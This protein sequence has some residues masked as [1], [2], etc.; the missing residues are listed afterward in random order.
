MEQPVKILV[1][2]DDN[3][4]RETLVDLLELEGHKVYQA[5]TAAECL[6]ICSSEFFNVILMDYNLPDE[7]GVELIRK[8]RS[9]N[10]DSQ[11]IMITAYAS[12]NAIME[13]MQESVYDF[14]IKPVDFDYLKRTINRA[15]E[16]Y[17]LEESN[18]KLLAQLKT[19]NADL[20]RL[21]NMKSKF[22][23]IVSHDLSNS[24]MT[25]KM[26][27]D[28]LRKNITPDADQQKKMMF[29]DE[30]ISQIEHL[31]RD[32]VDWAA[33][34]KGKLRI[35]KTRFELTESLK[36]TAEIFKAKALK[37]QIRVS[38]E[39]SGSVPVF[40]DE[41]RIRQV[42]SNLLENAVR[43]T[44]DGGT[45]EIV[46]GKI[47]EKN[48]KVSVADSGDG[49]DPATAPHLFTSFI[50]VGAKERVGRLGLGLSI[51]KDIVVNHGGR[52]WAQSEGLGK[53]ATF[54][55]TLPIAG[56]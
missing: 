50:Q 25:L 7:N 4:L 20:D 29:M 38:F 12:L 27:F 56:A 15:L 43:H 26:S 37:R 44:P 32:L 54:E 6:E 41:K 33:I 51:A 8:I 55:F 30:S 45:I 28:M 35:E 18:R 2:D 42:I 36:K 22:F 9:F 23:S 11:I 46:V 19:R 5:A 49:I 14:L 40:A 53:G 16:K 24:L 39:S 17:F 3:N 10:K 13:A 34:E 1:V 48:A 52:I 47:D 21:N 31:I